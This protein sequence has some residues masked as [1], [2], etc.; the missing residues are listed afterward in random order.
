MIINSLKILV[1]NVLTFFIAQNVYAQ[2]YECLPWVQS[3]I[4]DRIVRCGQRCPGDLNNGA[5]LFFEIGSVKIE[6]VTYIYETTTG[7]SFDFSC[8]QWEFIDLNGNRVDFCSPG[9]GLI[10][11]SNGVIDAALVFSLPY[12][13]FWQCDNFAPNCNISFDC[14]NL[15]LNI[16][17][18]CNDG[19]SNTE[20]DR[21]NNSCQCVG[22]TTFDCPNLML[23]IND[24]CNDGN[25]STENDRINNSCQ[26]LGT[27]TFDCPSLMLNINDP[28]NDGNPNT[29]NDRLNNSCQCVGTT[30]FDCPSLMLNINDPCND[31]K[32]NTENDRINNSCQCVGTT[33]FDCPEVAKNSGDSCNDNDPC[34]VNDR[35]DSFCNCYGSFQDS[36][37]DGVCDAN[38][39]CSGVSDNLIGTSCDDND[40]CTIVDQLNSNCQ[41]VGT[42]QDSD[43]DGVCDANDICAG[44]NDNLI[45]TPCDDENPF[46]SSDVFQS[47]C[48]C[49]G[50]E[51]RSVSI[52]NASDQIL[53]CKVDA[54]ER[55]SLSADVIVD[56]EIISNPEAVGV[57]TVESDSAY[58]DSTQNWLITEYP[59]SYPVSFTYTFEDGFVAT[60]EVVVQILL[61]VY[62][63]LESINVCEG[64]DEVEL[65]LRAD[66]GLEPYEFKIDDGE[67]GG[68][69]QVLSVGSHKIIIRDGLGCESV[70]GIFISEEEFT[71][72]IDLAS[73]ICDLAPQVFQVEDVYNSY[74]WSTGSNVNTAEFNQTGSYSLTV[75]NEIG[76]EASDSIYIEI[77]DEITID[78]IAPDSICQNEIFGIAT[79]NAFLEYVW[80]TGETTQSITSDSTGIYSIT[81]TDDFGCL[82]STNIVVN[83]FTELSS[84][85]DTLITALG[86]NE[87]ID[88]SSRSSGN[89]ISYNLITQEEDDLKT[90]IL[91]QSGILS[92]NVVQDFVN[93]IR[94]NYEVCD[95][96]CA[97]CEQ[98]SL[99]ILN[100]KLENI[101]AT[102]VISPDGDGR[103]DVLKFNKDDVIENSELWIFNRWGDLLYNVINYDNSWSAKDLS[104]GVY[105]YVLKI[106]ELEIKNSL[107]VLK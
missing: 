72:E 32:P 44:F 87:Q 21:I 54:E 101:I 103:N 94:I 28:C 42:F 50:Q 65:E 47:S 41:C 92:F 46:T 23:N 8:D 60:D 66:G 38:D 67:F 104:G 4:D 82:G 80:S 61:P 68:S 6:N 37:S 89:P 81:V 35:Y 53:V 105:Y 88:V 55:V 79:Q 25:P 70:A 58:I 63:G 84:I 20:N 57:W 17:D 11:C 75:T 5:G 43:S 39:L 31:G 51:N 2:N 64:V 13:K 90:L 73:N 40:P 36:D 78:L 106:G 26:C 62:I 7:G 56:N 45:G 49:L 1:L 34:T 30:T 59:G 100:E 86:N 97:Y 69:I 16:N 76:C 77:P 29:S 52:S 3:K 27:T 95:D 24:L 12:N 33:T 48:N 74:N 107:T 91:N 19:N 93:P 102:N 10:G 22:T 83:P 18:S 85:K 9:L 98:S 99:L 15:M 71:I 96:N 14:P